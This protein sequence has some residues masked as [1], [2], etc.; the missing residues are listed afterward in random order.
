MQYAV[1]GDG[2]R[3]LMFKEI[4]PD[5]AASPPAARPLSV[6]VNWMAALKDQKQ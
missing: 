4:P 5:P 3:F 2:K 6:I 1:A